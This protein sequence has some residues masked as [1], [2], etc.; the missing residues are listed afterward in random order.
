MKTQ[1]QADGIGL[2]VPMNIEAMCVAEKLGPLFQREPY[3]FSELPEAKSE[4]KPFLS[5][6]LTTK[7][8]EPMRTGVHLHWALPDG[9][10]KGS[11]RQDGRGSIIFPTT[12]D[13]WLVTRIYSDLSNPAKPVNKVKSWVV[14]SNYISTKADPDR[15]SMAVPYNTQGEKDGSDTK[16]Y[17]YLGRVLS[18][19]T[20]RSN[21]LLKLNGTASTDEK[22]ADSLSAIGYGSPT[23]SAS[24]STSKSSFGFFDTDNDLKPFGNDIMLSYQVIG[25][26]HNE[27]QDPI[28]QLPL[29]FTKGD[30]NRLLEKA[31]AKDKETLNLFYKAS[32]TNINTYILTQE[33]SDEQQLRII[34]ALTSSG[35]DFLSEIMSRCKWS[36][37]STSAETHLAVTHTLYTG[38]ITNV[39]WN[40]SKSAFKEFDKGMRIAI[41]NTAS[42][43]LSALIG[44]ISKLPNPEFVEWLM[45]ALQLGKLR[46]L[47]GLNDVDRVEQLNTALHTSGFNSSGGGEYWELT[48]TDEKDKEGLRSLA[49][50]L[51]AELNELNASQLA[52]DHGL[53]EI[54]SARTQLFMDWYRFIQVLRK[55]PSATVPKGLT[56]R[57]LQ[58][59]ITKQ[60]KALQK[61]IGDTNQQL[62]T[63]K[64]EAIKRRLPKGFELVRNSALRYWQPTEPVILFEGDDLTPPER[65]GGDGRFMPDKSLVCRLS[66][67]LVSKVVIPAGVV[68][69]EQEFSFDKTNTPHLPTNMPLQH[70]EQIYAL[71]TESCLLNPLA[72]SVLC[73]GSGAKQ[74]QKDIA[75]F[76][77]AEREKYLTPAIPK[78]LSSNTAAKLK[79]TLKA[80]DYDYL[81][82][83]YELKEENY[84]LKPNLDLAENEVKKLRYLLISASV[85]PESKLKISGN[86]P[87]PVYFVEWNQ[88]PWLPY[89]LSWKVNYY[90]VAEIKPE[91]TKDVGYLTDFMTKKF[92]LGYSDNK[93]KEKVGIVSQLLK[94]SIFLTPHAEENL[95]E[96]IEKFTHGQSADIIDKQLEEIT[97]VLKSK[98]SILS[99]SLHGFN[100][101]LIM[102][103][104]VMQ[105]QV[106]DLVEDE[107]QDFTNETVRES[108]ADMTRSAP[109]P[110]NY[111]NP[112]RGGYM[113][114][115]SLTI[116]DAF[117]YTLEPKIETYGSVTIANSLKVAND[118][119]LV[120]LA[121]RI[122]QPSRLQFRWL[123]ADHEMMETNSHPSTTPICGWI[124]ANHLQPGLW[125]YKAEGTPICSLS[126]SE[127]GKKVLWQLAP[128]VGS[129]SEASITEFFQSETGL[130]IN[131]EIR[132]LVIA[133]YSNGDGAYLNDFLIANDLSFRTIK[134][135]GYQQ[136]GSKAVLMSSPIAVAQVSLGIQLKGSPAYSNGWADLKKEVDQS[137]TNPQRIENGFTK[138]K[139]PVRLGKTVQTNDGLLGYFKK[140][141]GYG[142]YRA[143]EIGKPKSGKV[144][145]STDGDI[146]FSF[147]RFFT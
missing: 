28:N 98:R 23:F 56:P 14:E 64:A 90:P 3:D 31:S 34:N 59:F 15:P 19:E 61:K 110:A 41:G 145:R 83:F 26:Y 75:E 17:R 39:K 9:L 104:Q 143:I 29:Q 97:T 113:R 53:N 100:D 147:A 88:N 70:A 4:T 12:P 128:V 135:S 21:H 80:A 86:V 67:Q 142:T 136:T 138:V 121:P 124:M 114:I 106:T 95:L 140:E 111:Y 123:A 6:E 78:L 65:Y 92:D 60:V 24:Y 45:N 71:F 46:D 144:K 117:G 72:L 74:E 141:D 58:I 52:Y 129:S 105:L 5:K 8:L 101:G 44:K 62:I 13:R 73:K 130:A 50:S 68:G 22:Y 89:L 37:P 7:G 93:H 82:N 115:E 55:D 33:I 49:K 10:T 103:D 91:S 16:L 69:N 25:W 107:L 18:Y 102:R 11:M 132:D 131:A 146:E 20:W 43:A 42:Q 137:G 116:V 57:N 109:R 27:A 122:T 76:I 126:L 133:L 66:S 54:D 94:N 87:S 63:Q 84:S 47:S 36:L 77:K 108:V 30:F 79:E 96:Q 119:S 48:K 120:Y 51:G 81:I 112:I 99:Q 118:E 1:L 85:A 35:F 127:D 40:R 32:L 139:F 125:F 134:P 38:L 2:V